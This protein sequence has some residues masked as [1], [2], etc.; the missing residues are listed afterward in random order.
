MTT[1]GTRGADVTA[2]Q[3]TAGSMDSAGPGTAERFTALVVDD[4]P[5]LR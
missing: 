4:H 3:A 5:L 1:E 2:L